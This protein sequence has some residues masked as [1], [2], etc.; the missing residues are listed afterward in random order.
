M[1]V[2]LLTPASIIVSSHRQRRTW[3]DLQ[4]LAASIKRHDHGLI[5]PIAV[6]KLGEEYHLV[7]GGR[8]LEAYIRYISGEL[9]P[10]HIYE[11][12]SPEACRIAEFQENFDREDL[13]W[14]DSCL[15][16]L[17]LHTLGEEIYPNGWNIEQTAGK[18]GL[19]DRT[20]ARKIRIARALRSSNERVTCAP[21]EATAHNIL[22]RATARALD[23]ELASLVNLDFNDAQI[24]TESVLEPGRKDSGHE[25][26][27]AGD[28]LRSSKTNGGSP[29]AKSIHC[30]GTRDWHLERANRPAALDLRGTD[31]L[32]FAH[33]YTGDPFNLICIDPPYGIGHSTS[34]QGAAS[35]HGAYDDSED[36]F[37]EFMDAL[38]DNSDKLL[39]RSSHLLIW[40]SMKYYSQLRAQF[41]LAFRESG[42]PHQRFDFPFIWAKSDNTGIIPDAQRGPRQI[43]ETCMLFS[44]GDR[45]IVKPISN[46]IS[47]PANKAHARHLSEK[48]LVVMQYLL[49]MYTDEHTDF[50]DFC[51][52]AGSSVVAAENLGARSV[53]GLEKDPT[54]LQTA[55]E[56]LTS[57]RSHN[58]HKE[59]DLDLDFDL[60]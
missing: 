55:Q 31:F 15:A 27:D 20:A 18:L 38:F 41:H 12:L 47:H 6:N 22:E 57:A 42:I 56:A 29:G 3:G 50:A 46:L 24:P 52:G 39:A 37:W 45:K 34:A 10:A 8:R 51:C 48:P 1:E 5:H 33:D 9:I 28:S 23:T 19:K 16:V 32:E 30:P 40:Y 2:R 11:N 59:L 53:L 36:V 54:H 43:Y 35:S 7:A 60:G 13:T 26:L 21:T 58:V 4:A 44:F 25:D 17:D 14:Q 49:S